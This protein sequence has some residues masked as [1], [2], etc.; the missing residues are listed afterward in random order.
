MAAPSVYQPSAVFSHMTPSLPTS[1]RASPCPAV[2]MITRQRCVPDWRHTTARR[3]HWSTTT[4]PSASTG[5]STPNSR[6]TWCS[7]PSSPP[8]PSPL[9]VKTTWSSSDTDC[10]F[11]CLHGSVCPP[12]SF[13]LMC[14]PSG[15][16]CEV[17]L[18]SVCLSICVLCPLQPSCPVLLVFL[19]ASTRCP[20]SYPAPTLCVWSRFIR[21]VVALTHWQIGCMYVMLNVNDLPK[22]RVQYNVLELQV[23][24]CANNRFLF[25]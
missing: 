17:S 22:N 25:I 20:P 3:R 8:S 18:L 2:V 5:P 15:F 12:G 14:M 1:W 24:C 16:T 11:V 10:L 7:P 21:L 9:P 6:L 19:N 4:V 13:H 23:F